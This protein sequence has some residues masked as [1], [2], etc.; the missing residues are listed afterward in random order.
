MRSLNP[1]NPANIGARP[2]NWTPTAAEV[3]A[4]PSTWTPTFKV[5]T[6]KLTLPAGDSNVSL[7][8]TTPSGYTFVCPIGTSSTG[9]CFSTYVALDGYSETFFKVWVT[10]TAKTDRYIILALLYMKN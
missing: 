1:A 6:H 5:V 8:T 4:R 9:N 10:E 3:G 7:S 2:D